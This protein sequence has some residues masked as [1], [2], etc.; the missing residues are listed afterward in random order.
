MDETKKQDDNSKKDALIQNKKTRDDFQMQTVIGRRLGEKT[1]S[2]IM[3]LIQ[4]P[5]VLLLY[6]DDTSVTLQEGLKIIQ[7]RTSKT[8]CIIDK[9]KDEVSH[10]ESYDGKVTLIFIDATWKY[11]KEM[12]LKNTSMN[13]WPKDL[14]RVKLSPTIESHPK[15]DDNEPSST[16]S[17]KDSTDSSNSKLP[18]SYKPRR[19]DIRTP[20]S[21]NHLSTAECIAWV[22]SAIEQDGS[23]YE[24]L[25][26]PLDY[27]VKLWHSFDS[28]RGHGWI[29]SKN[30]KRKGKLNSRGKD[31]KEVR[32]RPKLFFD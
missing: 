20:P 27:M 11:A 18:T 22:V 30:D 16:N 28:N 32:K 23:I 24:T 31:E 10:D 17:T 5:N 8:S 19:F 7:N 26:K 14:V 13:L 4:K 15:N 21:E 3:T 2:E 25:M 12:H 9:D 29:D 6:P 1:P